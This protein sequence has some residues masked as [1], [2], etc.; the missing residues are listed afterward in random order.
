MAAFRQ[1]KYERRQI[2]EGGGTAVLLGQLA[3]GHPVYQTYMSETP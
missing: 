1:R 3:W 2:P